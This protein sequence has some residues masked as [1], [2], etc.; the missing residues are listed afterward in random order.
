MLLQYNK[1]Q[2]WSEP[3][4]CRHYKRKTAQIMRRRK[5][6]GTEG[7]R[8]DEQKLTEGLQAVRYCWSIEG[9]MG[10]RDKASEAPS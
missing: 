7:D 10:G 9:K 5:G 6:R 2:G 3:K 8:G 4:F 1:N